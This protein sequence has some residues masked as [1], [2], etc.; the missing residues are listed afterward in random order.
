MVSDQWF[1]NP[2]SM[3]ILDGYRDAWRCVD[4]LVKSDTPYYTSCAMVPV[5]KGVDT[6]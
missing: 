5:N 2:D 6:F 3:G 1:W 4:K